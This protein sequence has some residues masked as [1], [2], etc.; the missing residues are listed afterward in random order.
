MTRTNAREIA[1]H[2]VY[3]MYL[4][5]ITAGEA[6]TALMDEGYY[7][8]LKSESDVYE[9]K[10]T[11]KQLEYLENVVQ[12][13]QAKR[14][15]LEGYIKY[16]GKTYTT[17]VFGGRKWMTEPMAYLP[18]GM[19][20][21][22]APAEGSVWYPYSTDGTVA[23]ALS[24]EES[25]KALGY[26]YS[27]EAVF[28]TAFTADNYNSFEGAQGIC[29]KGWHV[30]TRAE[31]MELFGYSNKHIDGGESGPVTDDSALFWDQT[32]NYATIVKANEMGFNFVQSGTVINGKY[33]TNVCASPKCTV[34]E[35]LGKPSVNYLMT[36]S[37]N[38]ITSSGVFQ[39]FTGM[40]TFTETYSKGRLSLSYSAYN[41]GLQLRCVKNL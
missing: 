31:Y 35:C 3:E 36:S 22:A 38:T 4:N 5:D 28:G 24:D 16:R 25:I 40:T 11:G 15:E 7:P 1:C 20:A 12:G 37:S 8:S 17:G 10:P 26:L 29:P 34:E 33:T 6:L 21:V 13:V 27:Y 23:T 9:E 39:M 2:L 32:L 14:E 30:P 19:S 18:E 41:S